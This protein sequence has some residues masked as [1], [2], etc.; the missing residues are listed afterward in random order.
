MAVFLAART[1]F[2]DLLR[3]K[4]GNRLKKL[5]AGFRENAL[6]Y[7]FVLRLVPLFPFW[8][9]NLAPALFGVKLRTYII[10]TFFGI[11]P[12]GLVYAGVGNG[13]GA[14]LDAGKTPD[15]GIIFEP[16]ILLPILGLAALSLIPVIYRRLR[17][18]GVPQD[19]AQG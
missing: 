15:L 11:M 3:Q 18:P 13:L 16:A 4:A 7:M 19:K 1:A 2:G 8:L 14:V 10:A 9:V 6:S 12:G 17:P 5:E